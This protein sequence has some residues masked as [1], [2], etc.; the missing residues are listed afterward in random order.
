MVASNSGKSLYDLSVFVQTSFQDLANL[1]P[2]DSTFLGP[3]AYP[4]ASRSAMKEMAAIS[5]IPFYHDILSFITKNSLPQKRN[6]VQTLADKYPFHPDLQ[7]LSAVY[8]YYDTLQS[9]LGE[10]RLEVFK[11][12]L[13]TIVKAMHNGLFN[14][15]SIYWLLEIYISYLDQVSDRIDKF[16]LQIREWDYGNTSEYSTDAIRFQSKVKVLYNVKIRKKRLKSLERLLHNDLYAM[17]SISIEEMQTAARMTKENQARQHIPPFK[18]LAGRVMSLYVQYLVILS[19]IPISSEL[20]NHRLEH[21]PAISRDLVLQQRFLHSSLE[22]MKLHLDMSPPAEL[23]P[24]L[25]EILEY[26]TETM[27]KFLLKGVITKMYEADPYI[28]IPSL[29]R[30]YYS[31]VPFTHKKRYIQKARQCL[32]YL[33]GLHIHIE[34]I[35]TRVLTLLQ[36]FQEVDR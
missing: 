6:E 34:A 32:S 14:F 10:G 16:I 13:I 30:D 31:I 36:F 8:T 22:T 33:M 18:R 25:D 5:V 29:I 15:Y 20:V 19:E 7:T 26:H 35:Y 27:R 4:K 11:K 3:I 24:K 21:F 12:C 2:L 28:R 1:L 23:L 17:N 9:G